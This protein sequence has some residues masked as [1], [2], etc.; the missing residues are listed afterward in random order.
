MIPTR[1]S[2]RINRLWS[3]GSAA[4]AAVAIIGVAWAA[5]PSGVAFVLAA[6]VAAGASVWLYRFWTR[7]GRRRLSVLARPFPPEWDEILNRRV[8]FYAALDE[9]EK[10]R[11]RKLTAIF[12]D[13]TPINGAG[14]EVD[15]TCRLLVAAGAVI[16]IFGFPAW[17][18]TDLREVLIKPGAFEAKLWAGD[19]RADPLLGMVG[20]SG[21]AFNG[22]MVLSKERLLG[23]FDVAGDKHNVGIHEFAHLI[24]KA[25][26]AIDGVPASMPPECYRPW[27]R[28]VRHELTRRRRRWPDIPAYAFTNE[29]EFFAVAAEYFFEAPEELAANHPELYRMLQRA[30]R[31]NPL[32]RLRR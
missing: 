5:A 22:L 15:D 27:L 13:E 9:G 29:Q 3:G 12:V 28:L 8:A 1:E 24:D 19:D 20:N 14:C 4:V 31:Q 11:F 7:I 23:D 16:P 30:F 6:A 17:E 25:D 10:A 2:L 32:R 18:Y 26:G 21:G